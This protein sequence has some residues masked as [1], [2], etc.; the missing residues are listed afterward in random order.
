MGPT[1]MNCCRPKQV[2]TKEHGKM[3]E[4]IQ[5]LERA[6]VKVRNGMVS[7]REKDRGI[8]HETKPCK[9]EV[10]CRG[11]EATPL[12]SY[13]TVNEESYWNS[14]LR[15]DE[16]GKTKREMEVHE[17]VRE[18]VGKKRKNSHGERRR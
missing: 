1:L 5:I 12:E 16:K 11:K 4:R 13:E 3:L 14:W 8:S 6:F 18:D 2:G 7:W 9:T 10:P 15:E 17:E